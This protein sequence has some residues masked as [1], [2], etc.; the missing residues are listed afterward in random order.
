MVIVSGPQLLRRVAGK[1]GVI[2]F[3]GEGGCNFQMKNKL[4]SEAFNDKKSL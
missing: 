3:S 1:E 4:E 2:F